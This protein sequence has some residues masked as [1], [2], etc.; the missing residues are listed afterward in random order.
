MKDFSIKNQKKVVSMNNVYTYEVLQKNIIYLKEKYPFLKVSQ[1]GFSTEKRKLYSIQLGNG[2][3][4]V[5]YNGSHHAN[6][7]ITTVLLMRWIERMSK[8]YVKKEKIKGYDIAKLWNKVTIDIIPMVNPDGVNLVLRGI[9]QKSPYYQK[10]LHWNGGSTNFQNWKANIRGVDLNRNYSAA[11]KEYK[12]IEREIGVIGPG[13][14]FYAGA[15]PESE[16]E[17]KAL[18]DYTRNNDI[19][20]VLAYHSQGEVIFWDF[21]NLQPSKSFTIAKRFSEVSGYDLAQPNY[22]QIAAGYKDWFIQE[23]RKPGYTIEVGK[24]VNPI[25]IMQLSDIYNK[26]EELLILASLL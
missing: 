5:S 8:A 12:E 14:A 26:N 4:R 20:L 11:W 16:P 13:P 17:S 6:E 3:R 7:W 15:Y 19:D 18:A 23:F 2:V 21:K 1:I 25:P 22:Y 24:G 10:I 9:Q